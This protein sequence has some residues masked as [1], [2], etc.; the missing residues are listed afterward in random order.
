MPTVSADLT[1]GYLVRITNGQHSWLG[2]EP[3]AA[4]GT[5]AGPT[6]YELLLGSVAACTAITV[7]MYAQRKGIELDSISVQYHYE[8]VHADDCEICDDDASG[9]IDT[10]RSQIFIEGSFTDAQRARL[11]EVAVRCPVHKTLER[12]IT[13]AD[14]VVVG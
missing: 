12:G 8:K 10:V 7:S 9:F 13:F 3:V 11:A 1:D 2:D 14:E 4:G 6:P 5:E